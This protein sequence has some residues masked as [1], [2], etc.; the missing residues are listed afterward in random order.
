MAVIA[1]MNRL[2]DKIAIV[3]GAG[4]GL[5]RASAILLAKEGASVVV[6]DI[7][8]EGG[9]QTVKTIEAEGGKASFC[10]ADVSDAKDCKRMI[11]ET[12]QSYGGLNVLLDKASLGELWQVEVME[13]EM[14]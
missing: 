12:V 2:A 13:E 1:H 4:S 14:G 11:N 9:L 7:M 6:V 5:G 3:T 8:E 10:R